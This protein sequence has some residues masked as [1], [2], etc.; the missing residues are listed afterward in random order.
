MVRKKAEQKNG[1]CLK[2]GETFK[3]RGPP[4]GSD[5]IGNGKAQRERGLRGARPRDCSG[6][7]GLPCT[8]RKPRAEAG[9]RVLTFVFPE[10]G[11]GA[12]ETTE[13]RGRVSPEGRA[14]PPAVPTR[15]PAFCPRPARH[16][17]SPS[18]TTL[19][20]T[21]A[22]GRRGSGIWASPSIPRRPQCYY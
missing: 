15:P 10:A 11:D 1:F 8:R 19:A 22:R 6:T 14:D 20:L 2:S 3:G 5:R 4:R 9:T 12:A 7:W 16:S 18:P 13:P 21:R 17:P